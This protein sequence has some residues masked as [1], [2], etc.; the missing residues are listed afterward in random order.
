MSSSPR[1]DS[2]QDPDPDAETISQLVALARKERARL[3]RFINSTPAPRSLPSTVLHTLFVA[4]SDTDI[5]P[6]PHSICHDW[7]ARAIEIP[8]LWSKI[9][10]NTPTTCNASVNPF[11]K[12]QVY[13][14]RSKNHPLD[15][16]IGDG[17]RKP[18][19][20]IVLNKAMARCL[21]QRRREMR[22]SFTIIKPHLHRCRN[23]TV[24]PLVVEDALAF[25][26]LN[27]QFPSLRRLKI[28][29]ERTCDGINK[30]VCTGGN[31]FT[32]SAPGATFPC[33]DELLVF[34]KSHFG[35]IYKGL[36][37][38]HVK[39][40]GIRTEDLPSVELIQFLARLPRLNEFIAAPHRKTKRNSY[41][42]LESPSQELLGQLVHPNLLRIRLFDSFFTM[43]HS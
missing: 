40:F 19:S 33:L 2:A 34:S 41:P 17:Q 30:V 20:P 22:A 29:I 42:D 38:T 16:Y 43:V 6:R 1:T 18:R 36:D 24:A 12:V 9:A 35:W 14:H 31:Q 32:L 13:L 11:E 5:G 25:V 37:A 10:I 28:N 8:H 15:I 39:I 7:V 21:A 26:P 27:G 4:M 3:G 23:L